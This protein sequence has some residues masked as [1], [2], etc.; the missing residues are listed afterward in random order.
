MR[1][2]SV[3]KILCAPRALA[4]TCI[5]CYWL[6]FTGDGLR[7]GFSHDDLMNAY[8]SW[9]RPWPELLLD[10]LLFFRY[11]PVYRPMGGLFY[12]VLF[13][14]FDFNPLP[15][16][17]VLHVVMAANLILAYRVTSI[18]CRSREAGVLAALLLA[19][20]PYLSSLYYNTGLCY[21]IFCYFFYFAALSWY[22][23]RR[24]RGEQMPLFDLLIFA[25]L[26]ACALNSKE[27]AVTLP[28]IILFYELLYH[29]PVSFAQ[30][31]CWL[32]RNGR[33]T[34]VAGVM[35]CGFIR[36][37]VLAPEGV[38]AQGGYGM[39]ISAG[40]Y[41]RHARH[42]L[43]E[44]LQQPGAGRELP[45]ALL[46]GA[47]LVAA[48]LVRSRTLTLGWLLFAVGIL[49]VAFIAN[50]GLDA[51]IIPLTGLAFYASWW[52]VRLRGS[53]M[54]AALFFTA[55][56]MTLAWAFRDHVTLEPYKREQDR[57]A[58]VVRQFRD[59]YP[60]LPANT[61]VLVLHDTF[62]KPHGVWANA[63]ILALAYREQSIAVIRSESMP[64]APNLADAD[65]VVTFDEGKLVEMDRKPKVKPCAA[66]RT[67]RGRRG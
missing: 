18:L 35:A 65:L 12:K 46:L 25:A 67:A 53:W 21:D 40:A 52:L 7:T 19:F 15:F 48:I 49:P 63:F 30:A 58:S 27:M 31:P 44:L 60:A 23:R 41:F 45:F 22:L 28:A 57:I 1:A 47:L 26:F 14:W 29:P 34:M 66:P 55:A 8:R 59:L 32:W 62:E 37:R 64:S 2:H 20:H 4:V 36:G 51:V 50:R 6:W 24:A 61:R 13:G 11:T 9:F 39:S 33:A 54:P 3:Q 10:H 5:A 16:R 43:G 56:L 42:F 38:S 17:I